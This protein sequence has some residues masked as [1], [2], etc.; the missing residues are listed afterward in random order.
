MDAENHSPYRTGR[1]VI[2]RLPK[3]FTIDDSNCTIILFIFVAL[4]RISYYNNRCNFRIDF[5]KRYACSDLGAGLTF[6]GGQPLLV[7]IEPH[8]NS[9]STP[10]VH[11][12]H[13]FVFCLE[14]CNAFTIEAQN[15]ILEPGDSL[16]FEADLPHC[17]QNASGGPSRSLL[18][19]CPMDEGDDPTTRH[20]QV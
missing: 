7:T 14:G 10:I 8:A 20:F 2:A 5:E 6:R 16:V 19:M 3:T 1:R 15:Y 9:G 11:T 17:W 13:E 12:G 4:R 18:I